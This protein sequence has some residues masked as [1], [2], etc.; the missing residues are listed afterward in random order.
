MPKV[1]SKTTDG[2]CSYFPIGLDLNGLHVLILGGPRGTLAEVSRLLEFGARVDVITPRVA[3]EVQALATIRVGQLSISQRNL[4]DADLA[5]VE[6]GHY[7]LVFALGK[8]TSETERLE[9]A[10]NRASIPFYSAP[11]SGGKSNFVMPSMFKRGH[12]KIAVSTDGISSAVEESLIKQIESALIS[13]LDRY[14]VFLNSIVEKMSALA[15]QDH[16][17]PDTKRAIENRIA[18]SPEILSAIDRH[19]F[20]EAD[21]QIERIC[22]EESRMAAFSSPT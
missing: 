10:A 12:L 1:T 4:S 19:N 14:S 13:D 9:R 17:S 8:S 22:E 6:S 3:A 11:G 21:K 18:E 2:A 16:Y 5:K 20:E 15:N 7:A